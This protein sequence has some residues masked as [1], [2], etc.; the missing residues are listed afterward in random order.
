[1]A[2]TPPTAKTARL[3]GGEAQPADPCI[4][5]TVLAQHTFTL[6]PC[7]RDLDITGAPMPAH[8][9]I[10]FILF[11]S[12]DNQGIVMRHGW[13]LGFCIRT[14]WQ[15]R[16]K[17]PYTIWMC[18]GGNF[19]VYFG[20]ERSQILHFSITCTPLEYTNELDNHTNTHCTRLA[21]P[22]E[23]FPHPPLPIIDRRGSLILFSSTVSNI[24]THIGRKGGCFNNVFALLGGR[25]GSGKCRLHVDK[26]TLTQPH[27]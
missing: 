26:N 25:G 1:M 5:A 10:N 6:I 20:T 16:P 13:W 2:E 21:L 27:F 24:D 15:R 9:T 14:A 8:T 23:F 12:I 18:I 11:L 4:T 3:P 17:I 22:M 7:H 19:V